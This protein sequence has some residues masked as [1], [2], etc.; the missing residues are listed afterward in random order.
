MQLQKFF[1]PYG[2]ES[3]RPGVYNND[4]LAV[5]KR[6]HELQLEREFM[7]LQEM[8]DERAIAIIVK[9]MEGSTVRTQVPIQTK[10]TD[11]RFGNSSVWED[12]PLSDEQKRRKAKSIMNEIKSI[13]LIEGGIIEDTYG[14]SLIHQYKSRF[15]DVYQFL[16]DIRKSFNSGITGYELA[17]E[18]LESA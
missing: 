17:N 15:H 9:S 12:L 5:K 18:L 16:F 7:P 2:R 6:E 4:E 13:I 1:I 3:V 10:W 14:S 11:G 8:A